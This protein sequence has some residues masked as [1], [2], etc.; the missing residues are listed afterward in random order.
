M[1]CP[2][3]PRSMKNPPVFLQTGFR[4]GGTWLW[5]RFRK[6]HETLAFCEPLNEMLNGISLDTIRALTPRELNLNHPT[7]EAPYFQEYD[8]L[9]G[10]EGIGVTRYSTEFGLQSYFASR[11]EQ[12]TDLAPYL[13]QL[14]TH[15]DQR[16]KQAVLK[17]TRALGRADWLKRTFPAAKQILLI[18][19][20]WLQFQS[21]WN[22][23]SR[24][25]NFTFVMIPLFALSRAQTGAIRSLCDALGIPYVPFSEG[26][27]TCT[28]RYTELARRLSPAVL[29]GAFLGMFIAS[30]YRSIPSADLVVDWDAFEGDCLYRREIEH[31]ICTLTGLQLDLS[32]YRATRIDQV[33][34]VSK[35]QAKKISDIVYST[36]DPEYATSVEFTRQLLHKQIQSMPD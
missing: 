27:A 28:Q 6:R 33:P 15:A 2:D 3:A 21:G 10:E 26:V 9:L 7:L 4:T 35:T 32:D 16:E 18:R 5:S 24:H 17:F 8:A 14:L 23:A 19:H 11:D 34:I 36:L 13:S 29:F 12:P 25:G 30:H 20:P 22:M 1:A 31:S